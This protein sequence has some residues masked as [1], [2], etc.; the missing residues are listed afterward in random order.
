MRGESGR[1]FDPELLQSF[2]EVAASLYH[3]IGEASYEELRATLLAKV[4]EYFVD[5]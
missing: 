1:H 4:H 2:D 3:A 5:V